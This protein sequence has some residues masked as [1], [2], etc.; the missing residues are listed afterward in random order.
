MYSNKTKQKQKFTRKTRKPVSSINTVNNMHG[1]ASCIHSITEFMITY[2]LNV[3]AL[4]LAKSSNIIM[5]ALF[6]FSKTLK[7]TDKY[8]TII[9]RARMGP[10]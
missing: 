9:P 4:S 8:L 10:E 5:L 7:M 3:L 1:T 6:I 2:R